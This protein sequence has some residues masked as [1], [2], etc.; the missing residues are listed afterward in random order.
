MPSQDELRHRFEDAM[1]RHDYS[2]AN[3]YLMDR[4]DG[5]YGPDEWLK[6]VIQGGRYVSNNHW[7]LAF[8]YKW[9]K[10]TSEVFKH[11]VVED[12]E[13]IIDLIFDPNQLDAEAERQLAVVLATCTVTPELEWLVQKKRWFPEIYPVDAPVSLVKLLA[14]INIYPSDDATKQWRLDGK[15]EHLA[16]ADR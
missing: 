9:V 7:R 10:A 11:L 13:K 4:A 1:E 3:L 12:R 8:N 15:T 5:P 16:A 14:Q 2:S 6:M